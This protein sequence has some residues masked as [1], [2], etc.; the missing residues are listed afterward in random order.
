MSKASATTSKRSKLRYGARPSWRSFRTWSRISRPDHGAN[1]ALCTI[2]SLHLLYLLIN[3]PVVGA[4]ESRTGFCRTTP[5]WNQRKTLLAVQHH[6]ER[7]KR[8]NWHRNIDNDQPPNS[9]NG[10]IMPN[11]KRVCQKW[12]GPCLQQLFTPS[13]LSHSSSQLLHTPICYLRH[14]SWPRASCGH[15]RSSEQLQ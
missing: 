12:M 14:S 3:Q 5:S 13:H 6:H 10:L 9:T 4:I 11:L 2:D 8:H 7:H 1:W 15:L